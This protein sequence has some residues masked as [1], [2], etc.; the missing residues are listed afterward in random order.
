[1]VADKCSY[2]EMP[3]NVAMLLYKRLV[4]LRKERDVEKK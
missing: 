2:K 1:M 4:E 3:K